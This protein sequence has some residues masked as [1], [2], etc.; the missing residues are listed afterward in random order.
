MHATNDTDKLSY[1]IGDY[2]GTSAYKPN[3]VKTQISIIANFYD[4]LIAEVKNLNDVQLNTTYRPNG[5]TIRQVVH[6]CADSHM[7]GLIRLKLALCENKPTIKPYPEQLFAELSDSKTEPIEPSLQIIQGVHKRLTSVLINM[8][9]NDFNK[10]YLHPQYQK[11]FYMY[12]FLGLYAWHCKHH[13]AH[14]L[15]AKQ[16]F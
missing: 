1:P 8:T 5:W 4:E 11:E 14:I 15:L 3:D 6:H 12:D 16:K 13:L 2:K 10:S 9:E 7:N